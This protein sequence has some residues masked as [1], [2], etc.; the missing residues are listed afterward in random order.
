MVLS[1]M[2]PS[3]FPHKISGIK[4]VK[5]IFKRFA[6]KRPVEKE[7]LPAAGHH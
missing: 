7:A 1:V 5:R 6:N 3:P 2:M 4:H